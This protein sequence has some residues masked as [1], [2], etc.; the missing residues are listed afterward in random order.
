MMMHA[1][2]AKIIDS[3]HINAPHW[4]SAVRENQIESRNLITN[5]A[6]VRVITDH[7]PRSV[8]DIGCGEGWLTRALT[9]HGIKALG[10]DGIPYL[11]EQANITGGGQFRLASYAEIAAGILETQFDSIVCNFSLFGKASVETL[12]ASMP[13]LLHSRGCLIIQTLHPMAVSDTLPYKDGWQA[14]SWQGFSAQFT[15]PAPWYFRTFASWIA[16][17][18]RSGLQLLDLHEPLHP[19]TQKPASVIFVAQIK[20]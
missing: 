11:I 8:L 14:G 4:V 19:K 16:L 7:R 6:I 1:H 3:W 13:T 2:E 5:M 10:I 9:T 18:N 12:V 17:F 15:D 20:P